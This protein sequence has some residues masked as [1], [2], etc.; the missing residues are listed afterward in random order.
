MRVDVKEKGDAA[1][2]DEIERRRIRWSDKQK[3]SKLEKDD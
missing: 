1:P 2:A 3:S